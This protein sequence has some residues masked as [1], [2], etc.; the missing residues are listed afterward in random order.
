MNFSSVLW[1][2][3]IETIATMEFFKLNVALCGSQYNNRFRVG[4]YRAH[5]KNTL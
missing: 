5:V 3:S 4:F 2:R 1:K